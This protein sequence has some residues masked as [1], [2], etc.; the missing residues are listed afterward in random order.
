MNDYEGMTKILE[1]MS[2]E[3]QKSRELYKTPKEAV[4]KFYKIQQQ[5]GYMGDVSHLSKLAKELVRSYQVVSGVDVSKIYNM[6]EKLKELYSANGTMFKYEGTLK[7]AQT[8]VDTV[9]W[10]NYDVSHIAKILQEVLQERLEN[11]KNSKEVDMEKVA[12]DVAEKYL[13]EKEEYSEKEDSEKASES[14]K[15]SNLANKLAIISI[16]VTLMIGIPQIMF[17]YLS[18]RNSKPTTEET[19]SVMVV[20]N[21][22][23]NDV[24]VDV[25]YLNAYNYRMICR[26][27]VM[28]RIKPDCSSRVT[29]HLDMG[30]V[31]IITDKYKKWIEI[32]WENEQ[33]EY[34]SGWIQ[35]YKV[36]E[37]K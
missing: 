11:V 19:R 9:V 8:L 18:Y 32:T 25:N 21:Y 1:I 29:G 31:I 6:Q 35:N 20:N 15:S 17:A 16:I 13:K 30:Q 5:M 7:A 23:K 33:G 26:E 22:F 37:F 12:D 3:L 27:N 4:K 28:A 34:C 24:G 2:K 36:T 10:P 14:D